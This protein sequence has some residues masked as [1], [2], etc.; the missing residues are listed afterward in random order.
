MGNKLYASVTIDESQ[1]IQF[2]TDNEGQIFGY[3]PEQLIGESLVTILP[4]DVADYHSS[5]VVAF[6]RSSAIAK[7]MGGDSERKVRGLH[8]DGS[9]VHLE[10]AISKM[11]TGHFVGLIVAEVSD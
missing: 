7:E 5:M 10:V 11:Q 9:E 4:D 3:T 2:F 6:A 1:I 8:K